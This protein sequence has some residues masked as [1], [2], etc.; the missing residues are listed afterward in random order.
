M[1]LLGDG[2]IQDWVSAEKMLA[3]M[4]AAGIERVVLVGEYFQQ[5][6]NCVRRNSHVL[7]LINR[8]PQRIS[9]YAIIQP[10]AGQAAI[11]ELK[12][13]IDGGMTGVGELNPYAQGFGL[14]DADMR[15]IASFCV[16]HNLPINL[17]A[18]E[19]VG[20][21]YTGKS[22]T[23]L[24]DYYELAVQFPALK[25]IF[26]HWGGGLLFYEMMP[27]TRK[28]LQNVWYDTAASPLLYPTKR[29]FQTALSCVD[30]S[31]I[32]Y[33]SDYPLRVYPSRM[34][35]ADFQPFINAIRKQQLGDDVEAQ[36][37]AGNY[38]AMEGKRVNGEQLSMN[39]KEVDVQ[40]VGAMS[41]RRMV[42]TWPETREVFGRF[43][44]PINQLAP[45]WEP[46]AQ[47]VAAQGLTQSQQ[48]AL[49]AAL[50]TILKQG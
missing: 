23:P 16:E 14:L 43:N 10:K 3:D 38:L 7:D 5:H 37:F 17:H 27:R 32:L 46:I 26:A 28:Q 47:A 42:E 29:I 25:L 2:S 36:I 9:G 11:D 44:I 4:D 48:T 40:V 49:L 13:C 6:A 20:R 41:L 45:H 15:R 22:T 24:H 35:S 21:Y 39:S 50:T 34:E 30:P 19:P 18:G 1:L 33:G 31:K 12:R 8:Y